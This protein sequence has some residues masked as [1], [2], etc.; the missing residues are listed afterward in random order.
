MEDYDDNHQQPWLG[1]KD[2]LTT[3]IVSNGE[4]VNIGNDA[5]YGGSTQTNLGFKALS[6]V[7]LAEGLTSI[8]N[9]AFSYGCTALQF[10]KLPSTLRSIRGGAFHTSGLTSLEIP[11]SVTSIGV[12]TFKNHVLNSIILNTNTE[13]ITNDDYKNGAFGQNGATNS[14]QTITIGSTVTSLGEAT[15]TGCKNI[16]SV[17]CMGDIPPVLGSG[18][19]AVF[20]RLDRQNKTNLYVPRGKTATYTAAGWTNFKSVTEVDVY[21]VTYD[22][23]HS[24][25]G[26]IPYPNQRIAA[27]TKIVPYTAPSRKGYTFEGWYTEP[28]CTYAWNFNDIPAQNVNLYAKWM[29]I[30]SL[31]HIQWSAVKT[32]TY[33]DTLYRA[34]ADNVGNPAG[35][36]M[37]FVYRNGEYPYPETYMPEALNT[38]V[39]VIRYIPQAPY[40]IP[41]C[42][43]TTMTVR[44]LPR[45]DYKKER[46]VGFTQDTSYNIDGTNFAADTAGAI[47][48]QEKHLGKSISLVRTG[49]TDTVWLNIPARPKKLTLNFIRD[50]GTGNGK[51]KV[52]Y[53]KAVGTAYRRAGTAD[54][55]T[56][57]TNL[58]VTQKF[59]QGLPA[60]YYEVY[61]PA[62][63]SSFK[64]PI[65]VQKVWKD[66]NCCKK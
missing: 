20:Y 40:V 37:G 29:P 62:T 54:P 7:S 30:P 36:K 65:E 35:S 38:D 17:T 12:N 66:N 27:G 34:L 43:D 9:K 56:R 44:V 55:W 21:D 63:N 51:I 23:Q 28:Q 58:D 11:P 32:L 61:R 25:E 31:Q 39:Y 42:K 53:E 18:A 47:A 52:L 50:N 16:T 45:I 26:N 24:D 59:I 33:G 46:L 14:L 48:L 64:S 19:D 57:S 49:R 41:Y 6:S 13:G 60:G 5:F 10:I 8:G 1:I 3:V 22:L 2:T 15:F 4:V